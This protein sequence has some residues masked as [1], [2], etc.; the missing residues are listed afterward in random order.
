MKSFLAISLL[1]ANVSIGTPSVLAQTTQLESRQQPTLDL[2]R[3]FSTAPDR[4]TIRVL[5][6]QEMQETRGTLGPVVVRA[7]I[8]AAFGAGGQ[9][10]ENIQNDQPI[11]QGMEYAITVGAMGG[12]AAG[13]LVQASGGGL[14]AEVAW[15][16]GITAVVQGIQ[17]GNP[18]NQQHRNDY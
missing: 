5:N 9:L 7:A 15:R 16:P 10:Y 8:G 3:V 14:A 18:A 4:S 11:T 6:Q 17:L 2:Q 13:K 12:G 1:T